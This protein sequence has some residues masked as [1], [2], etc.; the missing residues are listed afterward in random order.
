LVGKCYFHVC[1]FL[2]Q[3]GGYGRIKN[4][5]NQFPS[6]ALPLAHN[7]SDLMTSTGAAHWGLERLSMSSPY[8][9]PAGAIVV[10]KA[11]SPGTAHPTAGDIAIADGSG[12]FYNGGLMGY[13][14]PDGWKRSPTAHLLGVYV[15]R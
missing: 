15:P 1:Q 13:S 9:A 7:F 4:P 8:D 3:C 2:I 10:V 5:Y 12:H 6:W 11:G 14:G